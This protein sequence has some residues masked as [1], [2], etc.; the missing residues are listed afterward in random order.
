MNSNN[1]A[2]NPSYSFQFDREDPDNWLSAAE[3]MTD[4]QEAYLKILCEKANE[5]FD[6]QLTKGEAS[7]KIG[8]LRK[9]VYGAAE[10]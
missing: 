10:R 3:P 4:P 7:K 1:G 9:K 2:K 5:T 8:E 6:P